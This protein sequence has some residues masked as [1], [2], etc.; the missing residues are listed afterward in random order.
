MAS[1][2]QRRKNYKPWRPGRRPG[3]SPAKQAA[4]EKVAAD[5]GLPEL[6]PRASAPS[7]P[8]DAAKQAETV[9]ELAGL[10]LPAADI[11]ALAGC[12]ERDLMPGGR[13]RRDV[14]VGLAAENVAV[15][16]K[17]RDLALSGNSTAI[18]Y[19]TKARMGWNEGGSRETME[20]KE[21]R[22]IR[23]ISWN[24]IE[25]G[26]PAPIRPPVGVQPT[27][28]PTG[29]TEPDVTERYEEVGEGEV[30]PPDATPETVPEQTWDLAKETA[31]A[32]SS[33][34]L[35]ERILG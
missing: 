25:G 7:N 9:Q 26:A 29:P 24:I 20:Q 3:S 28:L 16:R 21:P 30:T 15:A 33:E 4:A 8:D 11:A 35:R 22:R 27:A 34:S 2:N 17:L 13:L 32:A 10:G 12:L 14:E 23:S 1:H 31:E 19:W 18:L 5:L 6:D